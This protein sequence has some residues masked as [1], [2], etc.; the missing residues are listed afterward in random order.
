MREQ[1]AKVMFDFRPLQQ[2]ISRGR[3]GVNALQPSMLVE[4]VSFKRH[5]TVE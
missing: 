2:K 3:Q 5:H 1:H 4:Q